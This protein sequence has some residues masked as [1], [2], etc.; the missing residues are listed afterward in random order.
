MGSG[1]SSAYQLTK[2][3][4]AA[5]S[6]GLTEAFG[7]AP[8]L[9]GKLEKL[10]A[11]AD[12]SEKLEEE[13]SALQ[14]R[15]K[16]LEDAQKDAVSE[17]NPSDPSKEA[18]TAAPID[19]EADNPA[20]K[21]CKGIHQAAEEG[22]VGAV[23]HFL[24]VDPESLE[25]KD[26]KRKGR[27]PLHLAAEKGRVEVV[28]LLLRFGAS[29][30][31]TDRDGWTAW[32]GAAEYGHAAVVEQLI[33]AGAKVDAANNKGF[34]ALHVAA[35]NGHAA[36]VEQL[37]SAGAK[38]DAANNFGT[39]ALLLAAEQ[40][41][42]AVVKQL[43][44]AG[45]TVDAANKAGGTAL[46]GAASRD[47][48]GHA[49]VVEQLISARANV[50]A[51]KNDG[52]TPYDLAREFVGT[53]Q[54]EP[55]VP[56][57]SLKD[58][59][60]LARTG[61]RFL[62]MTGDGVLSEDEMV[63]LLA[64]LL[65]IPAS[66]ARDWFQ[67]ADANRDG[68]VHTHEFIQWLTGNPPMAT[69]KEAE[70]D[71][72]KMLQCSLVNTSAAVGQVATLVVR[73][74]I[75]VSFPLGNPS[76]ITLEPGETKTVTMATID[77]GSYR[78]NLWWKR[79]AK[80]R[81]QPLQIED[82][83]SAF[84]DPSFPHDESSIV[85]PARKELRL[86]KPQFWMRARMLGDPGYAVLFDQVRPQDIQQGGV[87]DCWLM[88]ALGALA[89]HPN[90]LKALFDTK[91]LSEDG[92]YKIWLYDI[93]EKK[94]CQVE[95]DEFLPCAMKDA[96]PCPVFARPL[97]NELWVLL[98][99]KALAKFCGSY[100]ALDRGYSG[101]AFQVLT[102]KP[103]LVLFS[104]QRHYW[105]KAGVKPPRNPQDARNPRCMR[106]SQSIF[107]TMIHHDDFF[108]TL[109]SYVEDKHVVNCSIYKKGGELEGKLENGL[110]LLHAYAL[111]K[112]ISEKL[113]DGTPVKLMQLGNPWGH[114]EWKGDWSDYDKWQEG[115]LASS[116][117]AE[118]PQLAKRLDVQRKDDGSFFMSYEDWNA[119]FSNV[120]LCQV[121]NKPV[122][123]EEL[124]EEEMEAEEPQGFFSR[125][126][127][128]LLV[129]RMGSGSSA[130]HHLTKE[131]AAVVSAGL[132]QAP[133]LKDK[134]EKLQAYPMFRDLLLLHPLEAEKS[135]QLEE[136]VLTLQKRVKELEAENAAPIDPEAD[137]AAAE[138]CENICEAAQKGNV[139]AVR[140]FLRAEPESLERK[141]K[142]MTP[143]LVA[144]EE[145]HSEVV[146]LLLKSGAS[147]E[148]T[149][150]SGQTPLHRAA[151]Q[152][153]VEVVELLLKSGSP[154]E[155]PDKFGVSALHWAASEGRAVVAEK[156]IA[157]GAK[158]EA[159][160]GDGQTP[161]FK[162]A[163]YGHVSVV[164]QLLKSGASVEARDSFG[165]TPLFDAA[166][167]GCVEVV[168]QLLK[169][170]ASVGVQSKTPLHAAAWNGQAEVVEKLIA[171]GAKVD[172]TNGAGETAYD[173]AKNEGHQKV[174]D[175]LKPA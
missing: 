19:T 122:P 130:A 68:V 52:K 31:A 71:G 111:V 100:G 156:L 174:M 10:Q 175:L 28:A 143:L 108:Q 21:D 121:G 166:Q 54:V 76:E 103:D 30:E 163:F 97:G 116:K 23:R 146:A 13:V 91:H 33:S 69:W 14:K 113:D 73:D 2:E 150:N 5:V 83:A 36:L 95:V 107:A 125:V 26:E 110:I 38:V 153:H 24:R 132:T 40:G 140:Y 161:L 171:A 82:D 141:E 35:R 90:K 165:Q 106:V 94:W 25:R 120:Y 88:S 173:L 55:P 126:F 84:K 50:D 61:P 117:W 96:M 89:T 152:G 99:E 58:S 63:S 80:F 20:A 131:E 105:I 11:A 145:G 9:K 137:K 147:L 168:E 43:I 70:A 8:S 3:E 62:N 144:A 158:V 18:E 49:A 41:R 112:V 135:E 57:I 128:W 64:E 162:A 16:E 44:S 157:A 67:K 118:N 32:L 119:N 134:L 104:K 27:T 4:A 155:T 59:E 124:A 123:P 151:S 34:T 15:V 136:E 53:E 169:S 133:S 47:S 46:H 148:A 170:G 92:K 75:D 139:A 78:N 93:Y 6:S 86:G 164:E 66:R 98:L 56:R 142:G 17:R 12:K 72:K 39:T 109:Q 154:V 172:A 74:P 101:W 129:V 37:I 160:T 127:G 87:G 159:T 42:A 85:D 79:S 114:G 48:R 65:E 60:G 45:A 138:E 29:V 7:Q 22:N 1:S 149:E 167:R 51:A 81:S 115:R 102:G 77:A